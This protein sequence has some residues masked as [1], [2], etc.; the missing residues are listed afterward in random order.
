[1]ECGWGSAPGWA[2]QHQA[3]RGHLVWP[4]PPLLKLS[5]AAGASPCGRR[6]RAELLPDYNLLLSACLQ[7]AG[8]AYSGHHLLFP[9]IRLPLTA[10]GAVGAARWQQVDG[11]FGLR[12]GSLVSSQ[13]SCGV[14]SNNAAMASHSTSPHILPSRCCALPS[15]PSR[16]RPSTLRPSSSLAPTPSVGV[17]GWMGGG[18]GKR[19]TQGSRAD[20]GLSMDMWRGAAGTSPPPARR[21]AGSSSLMPPA[22]PAPLQCRQGAAVLGGCPR[23]AA[24]DLRVDG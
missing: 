12:T 14:S 9:R 7:G 22:L 15:M 21:S 23:A 16:Q 4:A 5:A 2:H 1:M 19:T 8:G 20:T 13:F 24:K 6:L 3:F 18:G 11:N 17:G 10:G